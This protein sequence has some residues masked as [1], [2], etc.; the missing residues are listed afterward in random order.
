MRFPIYSLLVPALVFVLLS[1]ADAHSPPPNSHIRRSLSNKLQRRQSLTGTLNGLVGDVADGLG[2]DALDLP[3][4]TPPAP[5]PSSTIEELTD[6]SSSTSSS[7]SASTTDSE[8]STTVEST[9]EATTSTKAT[10]TSEAT[11]T[12]STRPTGILGPVTGILG[13]AVS[14]LTSILAPTSIAASASESTSSSTSASDDITSAPTSAPTSE[15]TASP[16]TTDD[17]NILT[18]LTSILLPPSSTASSTSD[19]ITSPPSSVPTSVPTTTSTSDGGGIISEIISSL[20]SILIPPSS[21]ASSTIS[22]PPPV[23]TSDTTSDPVTNPPTSVPT[24]DASSVPVTSQPVTE[25]P[26]SVP[27]TSVSA[28]DPVTEPPTSVSTS[29]SIS[30][31]TGSISNPGNS[32]SSTEVSITSEP[33]PTPTI[34]I[35]SDLS[36][37]L[38]EPS[39]V[40]TSIASS[41]AEATLTDPDQATTTVETQAGPATASSILSA[42]LPT[43]IPGRIYP[44]VQLDTSQDLSDYTMISILFNQELNWPFVV[45]TQISSSQIFAWLPAIIATALQVPAVQVKTWAL[46]VY[47]PASYRNAQDSVQLGTMW[48]GYI[49][50]DQVD[51]LAAQIKAKQSAFYNGVPDNVAKALAS[52]VN[53][54]FSL[55]AVPDPNLTPKDDG[56]G[57][58]SASGAAATGGKTRQD[59]II[60]V[61]SALGAIAL[62]VLAFLV[63]RSIKRRRELAHRRLSDPPDQFVVGA[64]PEGREFDQDSVGGARR[65]SFYYAEDSL[66]GFQGDAQ[67][68]QSQPLQGGDEMMY[69]AR[70]SPQN[71]MQRRNVMP[72]AISA[73]ILRESSM[74][75]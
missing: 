32:S 25:P 61:V 64:R 73:P 8:T 42:P 34:S 36:F 31:P 54:G 59:A 57:S 68:Q 49:P 65:R 14:E 43:G 75:W 67:Q 23:T 45:T 11:V 66:R 62:L 26:T 38:T 28:S 51:T 41:T 55:N 17:G 21:S 46:Q 50:S 74:N 63:Y 30:F 16:S 37:I 56:A 22:E 9:T 71:M 58:G 19:S 10:T 20:T 44:R 69:D 6:T 4:T 1:S 40:F 7:T 2:L 47:V 33:T 27:T 5:A 18:S 39:L 60:G 15:A 29:I 13:S 72:A 52:H 48:L 24:S 53:S 70:S 12:T 35:N 3:L